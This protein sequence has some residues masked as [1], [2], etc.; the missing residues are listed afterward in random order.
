M[1]PA[2]CVVP[3]ATCRP[4][5]VPPGSSVDD[6]MSPFGLMKA[7]VK[8]EASTASPV[9]TARL[10]TT[11]FAPSGTPTEPR[12]VTMSP[13]AAFTAASGAAE[14]GA[15]VAVPLDSPTTVSV[16]VT[17]AFVC[18]VSVADIVWVRPVVLVA[19]GM[20]V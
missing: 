15:V 17:N 7:S 18:S 11:V 14:V 10:R 4:A 12:S 13:T 20:S 9:G 8:D 3:S 6:V 19:G 16:G 5:I 1:V 2:I